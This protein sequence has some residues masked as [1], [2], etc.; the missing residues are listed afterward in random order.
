[1]AL[2]STPPPETGTL[3][4]TVEAAAF[5]RMSKHTLN[6]WRRNGHGP[7]WIRIGRRIVYEQTTLTQ[8]VRDLGEQQ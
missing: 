4:T 3:L 1:M 2:E 6:G 7:P 8:W 5:L